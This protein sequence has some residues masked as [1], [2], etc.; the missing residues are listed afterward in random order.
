M[1]ELT[2]QGAFRLI[3]K[4]RRTEA[5]HGALRSHLQHCSECRQ[6]AE[7][8]PSH[9]S[10]HRVGN[11]YEI[12]DLGTRSGTMVAGRPIQRHRLSSGDQIVLGATI[13]EFEERLKSPKGAA[14]SH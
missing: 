8:D 4:R 5:E 12:E 1:S 9:A 10:I 14:A 3:S 2:R 7:I 6:D 13:L 11:R